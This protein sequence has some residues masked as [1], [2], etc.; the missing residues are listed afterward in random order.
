MANVL[1]Q[2]KEKLVEDVLASPK[3]FFELMKPRVMSLVVFTTFV[4]Y[5]CGYCS[6]N[7]NINPWLSLIGIFSIALG[8][9]SSGVLNHWYDRDIDKLMLRTKNRPIPIGK[10]LL[11]QRYFSSL[12]KL[13]CNNKPKIRLIFIFSP[14]A[15]KLPHQH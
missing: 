3:D 5:L 10:I 8:A 1:S 7:L 14:K 6:T 15:N 12:Q 4:G 13:S 11:L 2:Q 9:G